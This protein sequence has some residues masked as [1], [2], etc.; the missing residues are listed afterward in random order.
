MS[1]SYIGTL[2]I[3]S[4]IWVLLIAGGAYL[5]Y[6]VIGPVAVIIDPNPYWIV[7]VI[8][9]SADPFRVIF[10]AR[11]WLGWCLTPLALLWVV[12]FVSA[13]RQSNHAA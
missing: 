1:R 11:S 2:L 3:I 5:T 13:R 4:A 10:K 9:D 8:G 6:P 7:D 12:A